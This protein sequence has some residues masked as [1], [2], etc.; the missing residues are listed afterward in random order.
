M[1]VKDELD[2]ERRAALIRACADS[3]KGTI[4]LGGMTADEYFDWLR[5]PREDLGPR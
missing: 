4:D 2:E 1:L 3:V 5:G